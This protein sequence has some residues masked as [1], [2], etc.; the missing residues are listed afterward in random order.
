MELEAAESRPEV[1]VVAEAHE[2]PLRSAPRSS[3][4]VTR[5]FRLRPEVNE[6]PYHD[7]VKLVC[8]NGFEQL[9]ELRLA[10]L[11]SVDAESSLRL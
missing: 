3:S 8:M 9:V 4:V 2:E 11:N 5:C 6:L 7:R 10:F 1:Q